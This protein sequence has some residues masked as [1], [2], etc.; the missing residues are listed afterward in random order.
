MHSGLG[1]FDTRAIR[2]KR[3]VTTTRYASDNVQ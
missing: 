1:K 2:R 3:F